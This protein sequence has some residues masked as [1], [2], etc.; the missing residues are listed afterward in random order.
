MTTTSAIDIRGLEKTPENIWLLAE[1]RSLRRLTYGA[2]EE[3]ERILCT[4]VRH[5]NDTGYSKKLPERIDE[6]KVLLKNYE[7]KL[8]KLYEILPAGCGDMEKLKYDCNICKEKLV[9]VKKESMGILP[10]TLLGTPS[11][12][13]VE[14]A[15][16]KT[17]TEVPCG[18]P[19]GTSPTGSSVL[20]DSPSLGA[21]W[22]DFQKPHDAPEE[23]L[24]SSI[25]STESE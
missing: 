21:Q 20:L 8:D 24:E 11:P 9:M 10:E 2:L 16:S 14:V 7:N 19:D 15:K 23:Q 12:Q 17:S 18:R 1:T 3:L 5:P 22:E 25:Q 4:L 6:S 13:V